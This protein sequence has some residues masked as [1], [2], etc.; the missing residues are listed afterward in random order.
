MKKFTLLLISLLFI[1][2][3][4][5]G[6]NVISNPGFEE[7]AD[8]NGVPLGWLGYAQT[9]ASIEFISNAQTSHSGV[10]WVKCTSTQGGYYLL[11]QNTFPA[12]EGD[13]WDLSSFIKDVSPSNPGAVYAAL[14][15][16][17]KTSA[18]ANIKAW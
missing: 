3:L 16:T 9:G 15:I 1:P 7:G 17:A 2:F 5:I 8:S 14:K 18:G 12:K 13:V 11:Y 4:L 6:Q 10:N